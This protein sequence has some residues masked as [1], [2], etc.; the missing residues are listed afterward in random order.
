MINKEGILKLA[1]F[2][3]ARLLPFGNRANHL[4]N[5][6]IT[7]WYRPPEIL[8]GSTAYSKACDIWSI[9]FVDLIMKRNKITYQVYFI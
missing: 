4:T 2:G 8:L 9:G 3:L 6:V 1:D 5:R 7:L